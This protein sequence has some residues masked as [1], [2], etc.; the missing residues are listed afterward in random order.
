MHSER[1][2]Y[3]YKSYHPLFSFI[4]LAKAVFSWI[5]DLVLVSIWPCSLCEKLTERVAFRCWIQKFFWNCKAWPTV[6]LAFVKLCVNWKW[7]FSRFSKS[8]FIGIHSWI[9][10][11][12]SENT[13]ALKRKGRKWRWCP[14]SYDDP[15]K[16]S[17]IFPLKTETS[18]LLL[19][20]PVWTLCKKT[21]FFVSK[22][23]AVHWGT[24]YN[25]KT[26]PKSCKIVTLCR[27]NCFIFSSPFSLS[28]FT[29][30]EP[31]WPVLWAKCAAIYLQAPCLQDTFNN[32][33]WTCEA[34]LFNGLEKRTKSFR[35]SLDFLP[36][37]KVNNEKVKEE[38]SKNSGVW[39][40][41]VHIVHVYGAIMD[42]SR[43]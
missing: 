29:K 40:T 23:T 43:K 3:A 28:S 39:C 17:T 6:H 20:F 35:S 25:M 42:P 10:G 41:T 32:V 15:E 7:H 2:S 4:L 12:K 18:F 27:K 26:E 36:L 14:L 21:I 24:N 22:F 31:I 9:K 11:K 19:P 13:F 34:T 38:N 1:L 5:F 16:A 37:R 33:M 30:V 8:A